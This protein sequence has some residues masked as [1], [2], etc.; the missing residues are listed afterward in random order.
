MIRFPPLVTNT[1]HSAQ[2]LFRRVIAD[3]ALEPTVGHMSKKRA[4]YDEGDQHRTKHAKL[5]DD[6]V[7]RPSV[8]AN[9]ITVNGKTCT[10]EVAWPP[11]EKGSRMPPPQA[12]AAPAKDYVFPLD[13]F[14]QT[15][16]NSLETGSL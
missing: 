3:T 9:L 10:H 12:T 4:R 14:Q 6:A 5:E 2:A 8:G 16:I 15:A 13:P 7:A 11:G 1:V